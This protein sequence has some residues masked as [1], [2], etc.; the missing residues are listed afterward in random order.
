MLQK[1][2]WSKD[3]MLK[4]LKITLLILLV[5]FGIMQIIPSERP[6]NEAD[7]NYDFFSA[8]EVP[9][10]IEKMIRTSCFDCHSQEVRYPWYSYVAPVKWLVNRD[11]R[12]GR[13][14]LDFSKWDE[15]DKKDKLKVIGEIEEEV[16]MEIMP[17]KIYLNMH[18]DAR[19]SAEDRENIIEWTEDLAE[20]VF[21]N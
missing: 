12:F 8:N 6:I 19:L 7:I 10:N 17:M 18:S 3:S 21:E 4:K 5:I 16:D 14:N 20:K 2:L 15:L 9:E 13:A 1:N 11:V